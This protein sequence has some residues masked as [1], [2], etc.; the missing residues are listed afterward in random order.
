[1][2]DQLEWRWEYEPLDLNGY[3]PDF[4][5]MFHQPLLVEVKHEFT[6]AALVK[7]CRK[8][9]MAGWDGEA[10]VLGATPELGAPHE[11]W[12]AAPFGLLG[13]R[14]D[15]DGQPWGWSEAY[16]FRCRRCGRVSFLHDSCSWACRVNGCHEGNGHIGQLDVALTEGW[17][18]AH[19][20]TAW[21][22][23]A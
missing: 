8:I 22:G 14:F 5:L 4:V 7:H 21:R 17:R 6:T 15:F 1:M 10:I 13:E 20:A 18:M 12:G 19:E 16:P 11:S 23:L 9:E 2:F 3:I